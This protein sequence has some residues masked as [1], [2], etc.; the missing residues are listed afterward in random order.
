MGHRKY[1]PNLTSLLYLSLR[2]IKQMLD[3]H[4]DL[5]G[6]KVIYKYRRQLDQRATTAQRKGHILSLFL[7]AGQRRAKLLLQL[8]Q[9]LPDT[10]VKNPKP[11]LVKKAVSTG[12]KYLWT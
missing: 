2:Y 11:T 5:R 1:R 4:H 7:N 3:R 8:Y 9:M 10:N 12:V 6:K